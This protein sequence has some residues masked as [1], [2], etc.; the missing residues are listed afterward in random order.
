[1][2]ISVFL[3]HVKVN[4]HITVLIYTDWKIPKARRSILSKNEWL[5]RSMTH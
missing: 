1:M 2:P 5:L 3:A 4:S